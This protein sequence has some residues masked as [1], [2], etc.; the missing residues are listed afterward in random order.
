M[1]PFTDNHIIKDILTEEDYV[2]I[3]SVVDSTP[4]DKT[5][6]V[7]RMGQ[8]AYFTSLGEEI[9]KKLEKTVQSIYGDDWIL[10]QYQFARY[11]K[12]SGFQA[13]LYPHVDDAFPDHKITFDVQLKSTVKWPIVVEG[14]EFILKDNEG[15]FFSGTD[16][17]H[18]RHP[19]ELSDTDTVDMIFCHFSNPSHPESEITQEWKDV[20]GEREKYWDEKIQI[21]RE[22]IE[23]VKE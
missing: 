13:K 2:N 23:L 6:V 19:I 14:K 16:Q 12:D 15:L 9:H 11:S 17:V 3:Y 5:F 22:P 4:E 1:K 10:N 8:R 7:E 21:S 18:W 20:R